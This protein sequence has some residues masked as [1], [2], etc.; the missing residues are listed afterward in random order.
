MQSM[1]S[2]LLKGGE[3]RITSSCDIKTIWAKDALSAPPQST[4][5]P[6]NFLS[7]FAGR[8]QCAA[9]VWDSLLPQVLPPC[10]AHA[11]HSRCTP[12]QMINLAHF[13]P[14]EATETMQAGP[15]NSRQPA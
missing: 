13:K 3:Y 15:T 2:A 12:P 14:S 7:S 5:L 4:L 10:I 8:L 6:K 1:A 9:A 11:I